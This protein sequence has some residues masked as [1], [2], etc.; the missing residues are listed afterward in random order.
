VW[1]GAAR[2]WRASSAISGRLFAVYHAKPSLRR[3][4]LDDQQ[5][6]LQVQPGDD[7]LGDVGKKQVFGRPVADPARTARPARSRIGTG[8]TNAAWRGRSN[9]RQCGGD[10]TAA[11]AIFSVKSKPS[12]PARAV[13]S[14]IQASGVCH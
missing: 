8:L 9:G 10:G 2:R 1:F 6:R 11:W 4:R 7:D 14:C 13:E 12:D 5:R 3:P